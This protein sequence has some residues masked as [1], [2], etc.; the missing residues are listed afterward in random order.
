MTWLGYAL[1]SALFSGLASLFEKRTLNRLHSID[2]SAAIAFTTALIT[3]PVLFTS[4]WEK[5]TPTALLIMVGTSLLAAWA[6]L[7]VTRGIRHIEISLSSPLFLFGPLITTLLAYI[8][9]GE[10]IALL[11]IV[12]MLI[13]L[14]GAYVLETTH[15]ID[16]REFWNNVWKNKYTRYILFGLVLYALTTVGDRIVLGKFGVPPA[17]NLAIVQ[18][19]IAIE[20]LLLAWHHRGSPIASFKL[21]QAHWKS[22]IILA[23]LMVTYRY[24]HSL[25]IMIAAAG[26]VT[27]IKRSASLFTTIIGGKLF[28]DH[29]IWRK[30]FA[31][32][33][34]LI[35]VY[36]IAI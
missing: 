13:L 10:R 34:M 11:Q 7:S 3:F 22:I 15:F 28:H 18:F 30:S 36:L 32:L 24:F 21:V 5:V 23:I 2:F 16:V 4:S 17:L 1:L 8:L 25:A 26:L 27:A 20:F 29:G 14:L 9:L 31:C 6:F 12:G 19:L 35:G 33:I